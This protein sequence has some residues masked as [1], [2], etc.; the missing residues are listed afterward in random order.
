[1]S[2]CVSVS[3]DVAQIGSFWRPAVAVT[4]GVDV[5]LLVCNHL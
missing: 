3:S 5:W 1:M 2:G 4:A